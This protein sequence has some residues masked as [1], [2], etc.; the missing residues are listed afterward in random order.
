MQTVQ[1]ILYVM[2]PGAYVHRDHLVIQVEVERQVRMGVPIHN[3]QGLTLFGPIAVSAGAM[4]LCAENG[5]S[6]TYLSESGRLQARVDAPQSGNVLLRRDQFRKADRPDKCAEIARVMIAGKLQNS[7]SVLQRSARDAGADQDR[8]ELRVGAE[9][10]A[11]ALRRLER[12]DSLDEIR[13]TEG[14]AAKAYFKA[15]GFMVRTGRQN[16]TPQ[17]RTRR[18]PLDRAN[19]LLS[20]VYSLLM[21]DCVGAL[22]S[23]GLDPAV[24]FLH[25]DRPGRPSLALDL[26]EEFRPLLADRLVLTLI[27][28][29]QVEA[30][31]FSVRDGGA[32]EIAESTRRKIVS[33]WQ[34]RKQDMVNH[35]LLGQ[36][37]RI[38]MLPFLQARILARVVRGDVADYVPCTL[39]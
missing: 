34:E 27:N 29:G 14:S 33:A 9:E 22:V 5:V 13:G 26:M 31:D 37:V 17:G 3:L 1:N 39:K 32:V 20:F 6:V 23:A 21:N 2:T 4:Q 18:P 38:G 7:R 30:S 28:R 15:F 8:D 10:M 35:V 25:T 24:G 12:A 16:F 36:T 11:S 19:A